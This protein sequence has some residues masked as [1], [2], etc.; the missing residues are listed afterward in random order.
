MYGTGVKVA[1]AAANH[2]LPTQLE[3]GGKDPVYVADDVDPKAVAAAL[4]DGAFYNNGQSCCAVERIYVHSSV[5]M[6]FRAAFVAAVNDFKMGEPSESS[7]YLGPVTREAQLELLQSQVDD[8]L[9]KGATLMTGGRRAQREG[10]YFELTV[11]CD[12]DHTMAVMKDETFG[13][14]I[15]IQE[16]TDDDE[17]IRLMADTP[18]GLTAG[19]YTADRSRATRILE[20]LPTGSAYW[21]CCDRVSP[22]LPWTGRGHSGLGSTLSHE[23]IRAFVVPRGWHLR[24]P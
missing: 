18:Y 3:L 8:A 1:T 17:A 15:G 6:A 7:T 19:V 5:Y 22:A 20:T 9:Q 23:G 24:A 12:V 4:A 13:P 14:V 16:V 10:W 21:N 11:L 2:L